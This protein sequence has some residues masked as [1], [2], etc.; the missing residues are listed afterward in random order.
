V[1]IYV[2][3]SYSRSI[4]SII[5]LIGILIG[6]FLG[7]IKYIKERLANVVVILKA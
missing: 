3:R 7:V 2:N 4:T 5:G 1:V 6:W